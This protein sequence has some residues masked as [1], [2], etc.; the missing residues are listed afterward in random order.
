MY[1]GK[2]TSPPGKTPESDC[3]KGS[4]KWPLDLA[5]AGVELERIDIS[6][7]ASSEDAYAAEEALTA[8]V[9]WR[10]RRGVMNQMRGGLGPFIGEDHPGFEK[11]LYVN[12]MGEV[13]RFADGEVPE[14]FEPWTNSTGKRLFEH[15]ETG[16]R[17]W[18]AAGE[19]PE[20]FE[21]FSASTGKRSYRNVETGEVRQFAEGEAPEGFEPSTPAEGKHQCK[22]VETGEVRQFP[23]GEVPEGWELLVLTLGKVPTLD[24]RTATKCLVSREEYLS[25]SHL[26]HATS[27]LAKKV[28][29]GY[30]PT[31][32]DLQSAAKTKRSNERK[33]LKKLATGRR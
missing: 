21:P 12:A 28:R 13:R 26:V 18:F 25:G 8:E 31:E 27:T 2:R 4:G 29:E 22:N 19:A 24:I 3:Y 17:R 5:A 10:D 15:V 9:E 16:E 33:R 20:G 7:H 1:F 6:F 11:R 23:K 30:E 32:A 14:G